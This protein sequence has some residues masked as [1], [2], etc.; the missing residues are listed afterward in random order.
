MI[1]NIF[2]NNIFYKIFSSYNKIMICFS[3]GADSISL[4]YLAIE[5]IENNPKIYAKKPEIFLI[6]INHN[7]RRESSEEIKF[8]KNFA[9]RKF[10]KLEII[11][12][13]F[14]LNIINNFHN[15]AHL[16]RYNK[17]LS[18]CEEK[19]IYAVLTAHH[20]DDQIESFFMQIE[21]STSFFSLISIKNDE[22]FS[23]NYK[24]IKIFRPMIFI[25]K[26]EI[27]NFLSLKNQIY[28]LDSSNENEKYKRSIIRN[29][30]KK[31]IFKTNEFEKNFGLFMKKIIN[32]NDSL[33]FYIDRVFKKY[34]NKIYDEENHLF[35]ISLDM[36]CFFD[37]PKEIIIETIKKICSEISDVKKMRILY[38]TNEIIYYKMLDF[39]KSN[40]D[41]FSFYIYNLKI[42]FS[43]KKFF[44]SKFKK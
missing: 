26:K 43:N 40:Q 5:Y 42:S 23:E 36:N 38:E 8:V 16:Q 2:A 30:L 33:N 39:L 27:L 17:I 20:Q 29:N 37:D 4:I 31:N 41:N 18:F 21:K 11:D 15:E 1:D 7:I 22:F 25:K 44:F 34:I 14:D 35:S 10:L 32:L 24:N 13:F 12:L 19:K 3:G 9:K 28:I 6:S